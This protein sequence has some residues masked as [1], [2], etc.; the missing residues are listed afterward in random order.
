MFLKRSYFVAKTNT[1][2]GQAFL[3]VLLIE[4][5]QCRIVTV[6]RSNGKRRG[7]VPTVEFKAKPRSVR[8]KTGRCLLGPEF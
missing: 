2:I 1:N 6:T 4:N 3:L 8:E 7:I 5:K